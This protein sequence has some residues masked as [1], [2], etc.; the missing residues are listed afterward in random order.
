MPESIRKDTPLDAP[1]RYDPVVA[2]SLKRTSL[3]ECHQESE[4]DENHNM[5]ILVGSIFVLNVIFLVSH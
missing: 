5:N 4:T 1:Y 2:Q 3:D